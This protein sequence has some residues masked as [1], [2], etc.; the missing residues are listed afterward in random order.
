MKLYSFTGVCVAAIMGQIPSDPTLPTLIVSRA[1]LGAVLTSNAP[2]VQT[3][4]I[5]FMVTGGAPSPSKTR[6]VGPPVAYF[7]AGKQRYQ[8]PLSQLTIFETLSLTDV[9][10]S[11]TVWSGNTSAQFSVKFKDAANWVNWTKSALAC[12]RGNSLI[13]PPGKYGPIP[14]TQPPSPGP[15]VPQSRTSTV[16]KTPKTA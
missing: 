8:I 2:T 9:P 14:V 13:R 10:T 11:M 16:P 3:V 6:K 12:S 7:I 15:G 1:H 5:M 4:P